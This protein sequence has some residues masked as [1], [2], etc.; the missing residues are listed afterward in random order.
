MPP[1]RVWHGHAAPRRG[2]APRFACVTAENRH[3]RRGATS[4]LAAHGSRTEPSHPIRSHSWILG[5][6]FFPPPDGPGGSGVGGEAA[7]APPARASNKGCLPMTFAEYLAL[8]DW[9]ARQVR[10]DQ[11][12]AMPPDLAPIFER[13]HLSDEGWLKLVC[14]F[15]RKFRRAAGTPVS[16]L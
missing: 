1:T 14:D 13:L 5:G 10:E 6:P 3:L 9:T 4:F 15:R 11:R 8:L 12:G 7:V 2:Q 16:L